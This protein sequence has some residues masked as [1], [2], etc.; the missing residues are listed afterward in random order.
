[1]PPLRRHLYLRIAFAHSMCSRVTLHYHH[2]LHYLEH[3]VRKFLVAAIVALSACS[4]MA[5]PPSAESLDRLFAATK[6]EALLESMARDME[7]FVRQ[8]MQQQMAG[9]T[10]TP[11]QQRALDEFPKK[12]AALMSE[13]MSWAIM[14]PQYARVY[15]ES[16]TQDEVD[17][18]IAFYATP[19]G[20]A[21]VNKMPV[22]MQKSMQLA[23]QQLQRL[24]PRIQQLALESMK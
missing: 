11:A 9:K 3:H 7:N 16:F 24:M 22:V 1:M 13:E 15:A 18:L 2:A 5:N 23:Q 10:L 4:A 21:M 8:S 6:S 20:L 14:K 19:A 12:A 17:G